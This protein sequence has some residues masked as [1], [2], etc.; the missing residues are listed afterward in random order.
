MTT[1]TMPLPDISVAGGPHSKWVTKEKRNEPV[2]APSEPKYERPFQL[3]VVY[4]T[5]GQ[6]R[7]DAFCDYI[8][9]NYAGFV[10]LEPIPNKG[11]GVSAAIVFHYCFPHATTT[12]MNGLYAFLTG[13]DT[14]LWLGIDGEPPR[15]Y[16]GREE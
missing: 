13:P 1:L 3:D 10:R 14:F 9:D 2:A 5:T 12:F 7:A 16:A 8:R 6:K 11:A 4:V 15:L